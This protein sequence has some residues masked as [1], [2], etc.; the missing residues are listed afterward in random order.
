MVLLCSPSCGHLELPR[1]SPPWWC[2]T[3]RRTVEAKVT[4]GYSLHDVLSLLLTSRRYFVSLI[5]VQQE[6]PEATSQVA[7][8]STQRKTIFVLGQLH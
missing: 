4:V 5:L 8:F 7:D 6:R 1:F 2:C 3:R